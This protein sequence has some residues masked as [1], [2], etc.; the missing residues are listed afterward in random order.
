MPGRFTTRGS[1]ALLVLLAS[2]GLQDAAAAQT[3]SDIQA[4]ALPRV[5]TVPWLSVGMA[6]GTGWGESGSAL[7][8]SVQV[9]VTR[10]VVVESETTRRG[11]GR[12][13]F[14]TL[15]TGV[16]VLFKAGTPHVTGFAGGGIGVQRTTGCEPAIAGGRM[17]PSDVGFRYCPYREASSILQATGGIE[18]PIGSHMAGLVAIRAGTAPE[19]G[20]RFFGGVRVPIGRRET[21]VDSRLAQSPAA[22]ATLAE[23]K[24]IRVTR[25]TGGTQTGVLVSLSDSAVALRSHGAEITVPLFQVQRVERVSH[26][27]RYGAIIGGLA[28]AGLVWVP[29]LVTGCDDC[30]EVRNVG[31]LLTGAAIGVG[32]GV[33]AL[34]NAAKADHNL[35]FEAAGASRVSIAPI[36]TTRRRGAA[37]GWRW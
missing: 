9:P 32:A 19:D 17:R 24:E 37:F 2:A 3:A 1:L 18:V 29:F 31:S 34:V 20:L 33:G 26:G 15:T 16:N 22:R 36:L 23:G 5:E 21:T 11:P 30:E 8:L 10:F 6:S 13:P 7:L 28:A 35:I 14:E 12:W 27:V 25:V 4:P